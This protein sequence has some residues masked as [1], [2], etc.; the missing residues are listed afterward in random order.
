MKLIVK[1]FL[2]IAVAFTSSFASAA[3]SHKPGK[4]DQDKRFAA[5]QVAG[6]LEDRQF[7]ALVER[8]L[9]GTREAVMLKPLLNDYSAMGTQAK[10]AADT[11]RRA[12]Q[13][14]RQHK[15]IAGET[16][17]LLEMRLYTPKRFAGKVDW[18]NLLV[19]YPPA[20]SK[21]EGAPVEAFDRH[22]A[23]YRLDGRASTR[24]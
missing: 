11:L 21:R 4:V 23:A 9:A 5:Y 2:V 7:V 1:T 8:Q 15:A 19:A 10:S 13:A 22:G 18:K 14:L 12:D 16:D 17:S 24:S 6:M 20:G 3:S